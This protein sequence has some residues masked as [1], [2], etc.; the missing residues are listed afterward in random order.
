VE[1]VNVIDDHSR[2]CVGAVALRVT[3]ALDMAEIFE[4]ARQRYGT[5]PSVLTE[6]AA[7]ERA[8]EIPDSALTWP[9]LAG[10]P[11]PGR[12]RHLREGG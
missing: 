2:M 1:I 4:N 7:L 9:A 10:E 6:R 11:N 8:H 3:K 12:E 5:P